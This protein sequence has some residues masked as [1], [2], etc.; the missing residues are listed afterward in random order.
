MCLIATLLHFTLVLLSLALIGFKPMVF[1]L[2]QVCW[3]Y[4]C[5]LTLREREVVVYLLILAAQ[6]IYCLTRILGIGDHHDGVNSTFQSLGHMIIMAVCILLAYMV[7][8]AY[9]DF[10]Q[11]RGLKGVDPD[12][13][14][15]EVPAVVNDKTGDSNVDDGFKV[16]E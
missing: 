6:I 2:V 1:N 11:G 12:F 4:S 16:Q 7:G 10:H 13:K 5:Y 15:D 3:V 8:R 9:W 14:D